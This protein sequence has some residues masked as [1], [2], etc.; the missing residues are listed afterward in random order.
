MAYSLYRLEFTTAVH[1]GSDT[2]G[3]SLDNAQMT[4]HADTFFSALCCEAAK[5]NRISQLVE[6]FR[7]GSLVLS[8]AL[9]YHGEELYLPKP[10]LFTA[11]KQQA[12]DASLKKRLKSLQYIPLS[13]FQEYLEG[14]STTSPL[15][16]D[17]LQCS[18]GQMGILTRVAIKGHTPPL[19]Y[20]IASWKFAKDCGLYLILR[21]EQEAAIDLFDNLLTDLGWTGIGGKQ[22]SGWGKFQFKK[23]R[24]PDA[25]ESLL[26]DDQAEYQMLL[27]TGLPVDAELEQTLMDGWY[28]LVRRGGFVRSEKYASQPLKK[29]TIYL[30]APGSCLRR[31]FRGGMFDL[32]EHGAHPVWRSANTLFMGVRL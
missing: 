19:P 15:D 17:K 22:S 6:Y 21:A 32:S 1:I 16:P 10:I 29:R 7:Q 25:L 8:D 13:A 24:V 5:R 11:H 28:R 27:G 20:H 12:G 26:N 4:I 2:G 23:Y 30:L 18:F 14:I 3:S 9:P 31:R